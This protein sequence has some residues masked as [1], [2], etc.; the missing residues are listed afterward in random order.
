[1]SFYE[2]FDEAAKNNSKKRRLD[3]SGAGHVW[4]WTLAGKQTAT[5]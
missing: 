4:P 5:S 2:S 3:F 1:V